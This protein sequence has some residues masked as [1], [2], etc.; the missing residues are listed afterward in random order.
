[1]S[2]PALAAV[3]QPPGADIDGALDALDDPVAQAAYTRVEIAADGTRIARSALQLSGLWCAGCADVIER[4]L[5]AVPGVRDA[6]VH[7]ATRRGVVTWEPARTRLS[8]LVAELRRAGYDASPDV[9]ASAREL[10][11]REARLALWRLVVAGF[12]MM[13]VM[14]YTVPLYVAAPGTLAP[15]TRELL[16]WAAWLLSIPVMLF[17]AAPLYR[18]AWAALRRGAISMELPAALGIAVMFAASSVA[19]FDPHS[20]LGAEAWFDSLTMF[21]AFLLGG[22][23]L[24][25][26]MRGRAAAVLEDAVSRLPAVAQRIDADG[27]VRPVPIERLARGDR[28]R[29]ARGEAFPAD[30]PVLDGETEAD[31]SLLTG[32]SNPVVKRDGDVAIAGSLNLVAPVVQRVDGTG[33][34]T[35]YEGVV[36]LLRQALEA[37]PNAVRVA[38]RIAGPFLLAVLLLAAGAGAAWSLVD[39][40]RALAV[41]VAVLVVTCPCALALAAPSATIAAAAALARRGVLVRRLDAIETLARVD[42]VCFDKTGTLTEGEP[43]LGSIVVDADAEGWNEA[44]ALACAASLA[45]AS[46]H[47]LSRALARAATDATAA[48]EWHDVREQVGAGLEARHACGTFRLGSAAWIGAKAA[49]AGGSDVWLAGPSGPIARF[50]FDEALR[51]DARDAIEALRARGL[52][53]ELLSGDGA[54]RVQ[55]VARR[56]G[57]AAPLAGATPET[58]LAFVADRQSRGGCVAMVGDG[59]ND[60]PVLARADVSFAVA[61]GA[62]LAAAHADFVLLSGRVADVA[63]A[64][65]VAQRARRVIRTNL[66]WAA[67]YNAASVPLALAGW[68]PPWA[69]GLGMAASSLAVVANALR[70]DAGPKPASP[71]EIA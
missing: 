22:R 4:A 13:Q 65:A 17:S 62:S 53:L 15:D 24:A 34:D 51:G 64:H 71:K 32:E 60:A 7:D 67:L 58:K 36:A 10:R 26:A 61:G 54:A 8:A 42:T 40:S 41:M 35:R 21:V 48:L 19:T 3:A 56:L 23:W 33:A 70:I 1:M 63:G 11:R 27:H 44:G 12:C 59:L 68:L 14:M 28:V 45:R 43:V 2:P 55:S 37:R 39:P 66:A 16:L 20:A 46:H 47:P 38:D 57:L 50:A 29:V 25:L 52:A 31:E 5:R 30:G 9:A 49:D 69:A 18:D 6:R